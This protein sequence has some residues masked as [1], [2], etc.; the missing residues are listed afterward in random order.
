MLDEI[1]VRAE[2]L[3]ALK[4]AGIDPYPKSVHRD[5]MCADAR[6]NYDAWSASAKKIT[7]AGRVMTIRVHG[8]MM[9]FDLVD[10]SGTMQI[11][12]KEDGVGADQ[13]ALFRDRVDPGDFVEATGTLFTTKR[14]EVTLE[15]SAWTLLV[16]ALLPLP[17]KWHGLQD[18]EK[19]YRERELDLISNPEV[20]HRFIVRSKL[21]SA[22]RQF[23]DER[24]F[25]EVETPILQPIPGGANARPF[26]THHNALD[27]DLYLRIAP[28]LYLKRL[29]VGGF[30]KVYE[31]G[32]NFRNEGIDYAHNPEFTMLEMYWAFVEKD[33]F[34]AFME[35]LL[36]HVI[37]ASVSELKIPHEQ[38]E[39]D[40]TPPWPRITFREAIMKGCGV[41]INAHT[42]VESL[43]KAVREKK[44]DV[45][46]S[47]CVGLG[48]HIDQLFKKTARPMLIQ[49][50]W[51]F[52]YPLELKPLANVSPDDA[53][54]SSSV[55][56]I[57]HGAEIVNAYYHELN[58]PSDQR[59]RLMAQQALREQ[60]SEEAQWL[61]EGFLKALEHGMP[62]TSGMGMGIDRLIS[63]ITNASSLKEVILFPTLR[64]ES[65]Q[66]EVEENGESRI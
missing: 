9:F 26:V 49:P 29:I 36:T 52:D 40:F 19:R 21:V 33:A 7:L 57:V 42:D 32:R 65:H 37:R 54:K 64:P 35:E 14:G 28:E 39:V 31:V 59:A 48:E 51:V 62:P 60:G 30:E 8:K 24:G 23:L 17:E 18:V 66:G 63:L 45:D 22:L 47:G 61:D 15:A 46:F 20:R 38:G 44:I 16:K 1:A 6:G 5:A 25:L 4:A 13:F 55:Q 27:I 53:A 11:A 10:A 50:T 12:M 34:I 56:L 3:A 41:D 2:K 58:D 43:V